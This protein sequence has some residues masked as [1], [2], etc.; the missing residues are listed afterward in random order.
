[1]P[2]PLDG[3]RVVDIGRAASGPFAALILADLGAE[4]IKVEAIDGSFDRSIGGPHRGGVDAFFVNAN[5]GKSSVALDL[6]TSEGLDALRAILS[7]ADVAIANFRPGV[8]AAMGLD[9]DTLKQLNEGIILVEINGFGSTGPYRDDPAFDPVVQGMSGLVNLQRDV[10][11]GMPDVIRNMVV[12][13]VTSLFAANSAMAAVIARGRTGVGQRIEVTMLDA[14]IYFAWPEGMAD[15]TF[16]GDFRSGR[17]GIKFQE[18]TS[19]R[20]G[21]VVFMAISFKQR[22]A[23]LEAVGRGDLLQDPRFATQEALTKL[24]N[25]NTLHDIVREAAADIDKADFTKRLIDAGVPCGPILGTEEVIA[26]P[27]VRETGIFTEWDDPQIG[28][29]RS[30]RPPAKFAGAPSEPVAGLRPLGSDGRALL[31]E[32]GWSDEQVDQLIGSGG[33]RAEGR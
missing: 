24:E 3:I 20:D 12:D 32:A 30:P 8:L 26:D 22:Q 2:G 9:Y 19:V 7:T 11:T 28:T 21:E 13:K 5:R 17:M 14:A 16:V 29:I 23:L 31:K 6:R 18:I 4:V 27:H 10:R 15:A 25:L 1:M 33:M